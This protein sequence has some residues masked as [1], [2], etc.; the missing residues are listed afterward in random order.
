MK[1][2]SIPFVLTKFGNF[3]NDALAKLE[4]DGYDPDDFDRLLESV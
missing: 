1:N 2:F 3:V 4:N